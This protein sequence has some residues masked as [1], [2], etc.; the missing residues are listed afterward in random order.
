VPTIYGETG[1]GLRLLP[2][3]TAGQALGLLVTG[4]WVWAVLRSHLAAP[5]RLPAALAVGGAGA[6]Y[7]VGR[8]PPGPRGERV[9]VWLPRLLGHAL[10]PRRLAGAG[11]P[12]WEGLRELRGRYVRHDGGW[13]VVLDCAGGDFG[14]RGEAAE[15]AARAAY[16]ELLHA[17]ESPLQV[18]GITRSLEAADR[19]LAW[20]PERVPRHLAPVAAAYCGY[21]QELVAARRGVVRR[22]LLV[23]SVPGRWPDPP[24]GLAAAEAAVL[25]CGARLGLPVRRVAGRELLELLRACAGAWDTRAPAT[26]AFAW[27]VGFRRDA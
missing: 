9:A 2:A 25:H 18:V 20:D 24:P 17:L 12:G 21:W 6:A 23:L 19:P 16:R 3:L 22:T 15:E 4:A 7:A 14:L 8:W 11:V 5:L 13:S 1:R 26:D 27:R 10:R